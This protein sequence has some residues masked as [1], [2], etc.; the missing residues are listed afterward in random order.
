MRCVDSEWEMGDLTLDF[1][2]E[3]GVLTFWS[4]ERLRV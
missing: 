1:P 4:V 2:I 3:T